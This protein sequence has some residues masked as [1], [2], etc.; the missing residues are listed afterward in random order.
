MPPPIFLTHQRAGDSGRGLRS[1]N[2][3][4]TFLANGDRI[5]MLAGQ[6]LPSLED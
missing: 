5:T 6:Y 4:N 2:L 1:G 3:S